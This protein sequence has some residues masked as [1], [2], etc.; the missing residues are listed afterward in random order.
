MTT[1]NDRVTLVPCSTCPEWPCYAGA[2]LHMFCA[3]WLVGSFLPCPT[4]QTSTFLH[5][6]NVPRD[7]CPANIYRHL[8]ITIYRCW[9]CKAQFCNFFLLVHFSWLLRWF[10]GSYVRFWINF[11]MIINF[12]IIVKLKLCIL[13]FLFVY[14]ILCI[15]I[16]VYYD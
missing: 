8:C 4:V 10:H 11:I 3:A 15:A 14:S 1:V 9:T 2:L 13:K 5:C 12:Y 16:F 7:W 6:S